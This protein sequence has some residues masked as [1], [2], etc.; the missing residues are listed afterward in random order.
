V[1]ATAELTLQPG[2]ATCNCRYKLRKYSAGS[3]K[4][5]RYRRSDDI[6]GL[7]SRAWMHV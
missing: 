4:K 7:H 1:V 5:R 3:D 6:A 2:K